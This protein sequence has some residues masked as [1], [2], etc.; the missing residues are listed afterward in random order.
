MRNCTTKS[1]YTENLSIEDIE[2]YEFSIPSELKLPLL[3][4]MVADDDKK[5][6]NSEIEEKVEGEIRDK[7]MEDKK[8]FE[9]TEQPFQFEEKKLRE[10]STL[11]LRKKESEGMMFLYKHSF[12]KSSFEKL[13][14]K[15][16]DSALKKIL[17]YNSECLSARYY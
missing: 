2:I 8:M 3:N 1:I 7:E 11:K 6:E 10:M 16:V 14:K 5:K 17:K 15:S 12:H 13:N 4:F 9:I